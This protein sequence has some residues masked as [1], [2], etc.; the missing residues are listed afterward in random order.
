MYVVEY[1]NIIF[2]YRKKVTN[3][4]ILQPIKIL[5]IRTHTL[6]T[7]IH[8]HIIVIVNEEVDIM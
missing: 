7:L 6:F 5:R 2:S 1:S 8:E 3:C 4:T